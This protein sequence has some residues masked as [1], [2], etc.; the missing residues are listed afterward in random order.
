MANISKRGPRQWQA[1]IRKKGYPAKTKT[2]D[3]KA[4]AE[5]WANTLE[6][7]MARG[8]FICSD[9]AERTTLSE[10]IDRYLREVTPHKKGERV[11]RYRLNAWKD[12]PLAL[13]TVAS[14]RGVDMAA[15]RDSML[16]D[17]KSASTV[18]N[19]LAVISHVFTVAKKDWGM[20]SITNPVANI[21][22]PRLPRGR[23]RRLVGDEETLLVQNAK[24]PVREIIILAIETAMRLSEITGLNWEDVDLT[25][26]VATLQDTK[27]GEKRHVPLSKRAIETLTAIKKRKARDIGG[28][29]FV[30]WEKDRFHWHWKELCRK[31]GIKGLRFHDLRHEATSRFF[32]KGGLGLM[33][34]ASITGHKGLS[35]LMRYTHLRVTD[36]VEKI[37]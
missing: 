32:E 18:K 5:A 23:D 33:A 35:M 20:E 17:G 13:R 10:L 3:T 29:V 2:F 27:N 7:E 19:N 28:R 11:E 25:A 6:S 34:I 14:I 31:Q 21:R 9:E 15:Y 30:D 36:L 37:G 1:R 8:V 4:E 12:H 26:R 24:Y 16:A 22:K